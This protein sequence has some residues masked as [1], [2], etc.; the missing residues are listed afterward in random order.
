MVKNKCENMNICKTIYT[1]INKKNKIMLK[2]ITH[3]FKLTLL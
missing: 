1:Y 3:Y 2:V